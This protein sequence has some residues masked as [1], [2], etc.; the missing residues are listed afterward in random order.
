MQWQQRATMCA[1][2]ASVYAHNAAAVCNKLHAAAATIDTCFSAKRCCTNL[3]AACTNAA[4]TKLPAACHAALLHMGMNKACH[5]GV[6]ACAAAAA[7][8]EL[9]PAALGG[10][11][12]RR[13]W[14]SERRRGE[15]ER[16]CMCGG[17]G[18][19]GKG[20]G[21]IGKGQGRQTVPP[22]TGNCLREG[23]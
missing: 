4:K 22:L 16:A 20:E 7:S 8:C 15:R 23:N 18:G 11:W 3:Y 6:Q 10:R 12:G 5:A 14:G 9:L 19:K 13:A 17:K 2:C 21:G 1:R